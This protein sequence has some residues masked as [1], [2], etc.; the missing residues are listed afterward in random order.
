[1]RAI[2]VFASKHGSTAEVATALGE[3]LREEGVEVEVA[4]AALA[5]LPEDTDA[6][7][8][9]S[10]IYMGSWLSSAV[11]FAMNNSESLRRLPLWLFSVGPLGE[12]PDDEEEQP[13]QLATLRDTLEPNDHVLFDGRLDPSLLGFAER[14]MIKAVRAPKGD[15]RRWD[16]IRAWGRKVAYELRAAQPRS[17]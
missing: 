7:L 13:R 12:A 9:G 4:D 15:F 6:V 2:V 8:L 17:S 16:L 10:A 3:A 1:M 5:K 11:D 14:I